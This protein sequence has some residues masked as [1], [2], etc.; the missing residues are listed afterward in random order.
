MNNNIRLIA[1]DLDRTLLRSDK[2]I[3]DY[4]VHVLE[5]CC[6]RGIKV[7]FATA[8]KESAA[9]RF[10][11]A[12]LPDAAVFSGGAVV[13][14]GDA[15]VYSCAIPQQTADHLLRSCLG[16]SAV[17]R[18]I[19]ET[20]AGDYLVN[21]SYDPNSPHWKDYG[22]GTYSDFSQG[23]SCDVYKMIIECKNEKAAY[24]ISEQ[25][26]DVD[27]IGF[28]G[29]NWF[30]LHNKNASKWNGIKH[31]IAHIG[32][33]AAEVAAFGDDYNDIEML[34]NSGTGIAVSN[35]LEKAKAAANF[36]CGSNDEDG[37]ARWIEEHVLGD[38]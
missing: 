17:V 13:R 4:T 35:A 31:L 10:T 33:S 2:T 38:Y 19:V 5:Q 16:S 24:Q 21:F 3:S 28:A 36:I 26:S 8:R 1:T 29:E 32:I 18:I 37:V 20:V 30:Q 23:V 14:C 11:D 22:G 25:H 27:V 9:K 6:A 34:R 15:T 12:I 7:A